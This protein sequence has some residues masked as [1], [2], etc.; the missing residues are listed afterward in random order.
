[1][2][3]ILFDWLVDV[4]LKFKLTPETLYLTFNIIDRFLS[5]QNVPR[6]KLQLVGVTSMFIASKYEEIYAPEVKD[7]AYVTDKAY[8]K[9][10]IL[11]CEG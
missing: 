1:M 3:K 2:R 7:F 9:K 5:K 8:T 6:K 11:Q 10:A 4:H